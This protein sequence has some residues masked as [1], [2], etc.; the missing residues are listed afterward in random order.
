MIVAG[1][2]LGSAAGKVVILKDKKV[3]SSAVV[4]STTSPEKTALKALE[5]A[6]S[7]IG[8]KDLAELDNIVSTGY[9]R[10]KLSFV[11][12]NVTEIACHARGAFELNPT[13][14]TLIDVG[15]QDCK[16]ISITNK[17][18]VAEFNMNDRCAA[19]TGKFLESMARTL[20]CSLEEFSDLALS[21]TEILKISSQ[22][23]VFAESEVITLINDGMKP[24]NIAAGL[25]DSIARRL[26]AMINRVGLELPV[27]FSGGGAKSESLVKFLEKK[28]NT[29]IVR[30][31]CS[32]QLVGAIG[33][34]HF[35]TELIEI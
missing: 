9:G 5:I 8:M 34:A 25:V 13:I 30:F 29:E 27:G 22:C 18:R 35:A 31:D 23:S 10:S 12:K 20:N 26:I 24:E 2:D 4:K 1:C 21:H 19:G 28:L 3:I 17:G 33:A 6:M 11:K 7:A 14:R 15:G 32:P 16:I